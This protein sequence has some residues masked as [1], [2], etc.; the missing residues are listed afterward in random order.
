M[1]RI[2]WITVEIASQKIRNIKKRR[3]S[4]R[5]ENIGLAYNILADR[6]IS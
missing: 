2:K 1:V 4:L 6:L 5:S 3:K